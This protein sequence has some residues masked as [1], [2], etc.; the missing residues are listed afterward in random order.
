MT[1]PV[2][3]KRDVARMLK[4]SVRS[5]ERHIQPSLRVGGQNRYYASDV[6]RQLHGVPDSGGTVVAFPT[7]GAAA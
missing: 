2:L 3:T 6:T 4:V 7:R 5:V 1:E